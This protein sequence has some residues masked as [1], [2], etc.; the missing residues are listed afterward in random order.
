MEA[1]RAIRQNPFEQ[2]ISETIDLLSKKLS[3]EADRIKRITANLV[4]DEEEYKYLTI[5]EVVDRI[6]VDALFAVPPHSLYTPDEIKRKA[7]ELLAKKIKRD[8]RLL[9]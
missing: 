7:L 5:K 6:Y 8:E 3:E 4:V 2:L 9:T 1:S